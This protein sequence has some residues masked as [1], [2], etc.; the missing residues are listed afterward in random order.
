[1]PCA[2]QQAVPPTSANSSSMSVGL[3][4]RL[5]FSFGSEAEPFRLQRG[6]ELP[7]VTLAYETY[8]RLNERRDNV[9]LI[10]HALTGD[11]HAA[12]RHSPDDR[13]PGWWDGAVGP[14]RVT[15]TLGIDR[16]LN[17]A[18]AAE[19]SGL[20]I[21]DRGVRVPAA[22]VSATPR[23]GVAYAGPVWA[24]KPWRGCASG[25]A[26]AIGAAHRPVCCASAH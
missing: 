12:G 11:A 18:P 17:R 16:S 7:G 19:S 13:K 1:M 14:G 9:V 23:I 4:R 24:A 20:W 2:T 10:V 15:K 3:T 6:G 26:N 8:G 5:S 25:C 21:E 22:I